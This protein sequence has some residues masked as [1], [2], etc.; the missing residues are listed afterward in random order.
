[1]PLLP[2]YCPLVYLNPIKN[3]GNWELLLEASL[4]CSDRECSPNI[5]VFYKQA[6]SRN[7]RDFNTLSLPNS[8]EQF[9][10]RDPFDTGLY[11]CFFKILP[12]E[13]MFS[14]AVRVSTLHKCIN[15][16]VQEQM[17]I[18]V[19]AGLAILGLVHSSSVPKG[20][21]FITVIQS[22]KKTTLIWKSLY[23]KLFL[24]WSGSSFF[25]SLL[26]VNLMGD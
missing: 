23:K 22:C 3:K 19:Q 20:V 11:S 24:A 7:M 26:Y 15:R 13:V 25:P 8:W 10:L 5:L 4:Q 9:V 21:L 6:L 17:G 16:V 12:A 1:M 14:D 2:F 18:P